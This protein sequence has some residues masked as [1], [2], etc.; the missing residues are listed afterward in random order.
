[1]NA[2]IRITT[3]FLL[4]LL[5]LATVTACSKKQEEAKGEAA[6]QAEKKPA[7]GEEGEEAEELPEQV[8]LD[9]E[10]VAAA[11]I[12]TWKALPIEVGNVLTLNGNV[13]FNE[14]RLL[15]VSTLVQGRVVQ[16]PVDLGQAVSKGQPVAW[17]ESMEL[18]RMR[19]EY[20]RAATEA[21]IAE[22]SHERAKL[23]VAE[24]AI[25]AGEFQQREG[26]YRSKQSALAAAELALRQAGDD[27]RQARSAGA[28]RV[29]VRAPF[30][31]RVIDRKV[32]PG[33]LVE[34]LHPL[35]TVAD[36]SN[37]WVFLR[38]YEKDLGVIRTGL[39]ITVTTEAL[40]DTRFS[41]TIDYVGSEVDPNTR[42][43]RIRATVRNAGERLRPGL[44]VSG[45][46]EVAGG[47]RKE[48]KLLAVP[49]GAIQTL[50]GKPTI[51]VQTAPNTYARRTLE[52]GRGFGDYVEVLAGLK[53]GE[54]VVT[55]GSFILK[56]QF[57]KAELVEEE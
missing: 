45:R 26:D 6:E 33:A 19:Q 48:E 46:L 57:S 24:K 11:G 40:P 16:L 49:N 31:G 7:A 3:I 29:A 41:G 4:L 14:N 10:A 36:L 18:G 15:A 34:A 23:L 9:A 39:P 50:A 28:P 55:E 8:T 17:I 2:R 44:F 27:P 38:V 47:A 21:D 22:K 51:F 52:A 20:L 43:T 30:A 25:A 35:V 53:A 13:A 5:A 1:M 32:T 12:K 42:T 37:V 56:S 54:E